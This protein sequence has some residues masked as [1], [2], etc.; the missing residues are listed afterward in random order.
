MMT[1]I[2]IGECMVELRAEGPDLYRRSFA[3]DAYNTAVYLKRSSPKLDVAF[4]TGI[5]T[6]P[7]SADMRRSWESEGIDARLAFP[8]AD[9][10]PGLYLIETDAKGERQFHYWRKDSAATRW[11][12]EI[13]THSVEAVFGDADLIYFS[14]ISLGILTSEERGAFLRTLRG[15]KHRGRIAF[16]PNLRLRLWPAVAE[17]HDVFEEVVAVS[18]I[19]LPSSQD[20]DALYAPAKAEAHAERLIKLGAREFAITDG[21]NG[22]WI[23][24]GALQRLNL[25]ERVN[26]VDTS[27]AGDAF[28]GA[29]LAARLAGHEPKTAAMRGMRLA[30]EVITHTGAIIPKKLYSLKDHTD[31]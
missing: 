19:V 13:K 7:M 5:G 12:Q 2:C 3:G 16:D 10:T 26:A 20:L 25:A 30:G 11:W 28:N 1:A 21:E 17:A 31:V 27:G 4:C 6:D 9:R 23:Y 22:C 8:V 24:N 15:L 29:Y 14:G 18:D